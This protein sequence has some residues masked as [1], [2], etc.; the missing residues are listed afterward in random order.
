MQ[1]LWHCLEDQGAPEWLAI[2]NSVTTFYLLFRRQAKV[3][4]DSSSTSWF[5]WGGLSMSIPSNPNHP[6]NSTV[7]GDC[8]GF[9]AGHSL[10]EAKGS[11]SYWKCCGLFTT[12]APSI[13]IKKAFKS[14]QSTIYQRRGGK[15][16]S[17]AVQ[18]SED[19]DWAPKECYWKQRG[20]VKA[21]NKGKHLVC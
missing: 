16:S 2:H 10:P 6:W 12:L 20:A 15:S 4:K 5:P 7:Y 14:G 18:L 11:V 21:A 8:H 3:G 1:P 17:F 13:I 9:C 19:M